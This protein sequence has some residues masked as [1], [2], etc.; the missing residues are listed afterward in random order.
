MAIKKRLSLSLSSLQS[1]P[2]IVAGLMVVPLL[3]LGIGA[4]YSYRTATDALTETTT[5]ITK[6]I[7]PVSNLQLA[8]EKAAMPPNDYIITGDVKERAEFARLSRQTDAAFKVVLRSPFSRDERRSTLAAIKQWRTVKRL[9][10][11]VLATP[12]PRDDPVAV[13]KM[14]RLDAQIGRAVVSLDRIHALA[15]QEIIE[16]MTEVNRQRR[17]A[18]LI[19]VLIFAASVAM[20]TAI[21]TM[22]ARSI[23]R[24]LGILTDGAARFAAGDLSYR[25]PKLALDELD[26]FG[27]TFNAMA[28]R[29][30]TDL[31]ELKAGEAR[32]HAIADTAFDGIITLDAM[33]KIQFVN[34]AI[35]RMHGYAP[36]ELIGQDVTVLLPERFRDLIAGEITRYLTTGASDLLDKTTELST[37]KKDGSEFQVELTAAA[38]NIEGQPFFSGMIRDITQRKEAERLLK[39]SSI[40]DGLTGLYNYAEFHRLLQ[41]EL[42][43]SR[44]YGPPFSLLMLDIDYFKQVNDTNGHQAGDTV[45]VE[46]ADTIREAIRPIDKPARYGGEEFI[47][48]LPETDEAG[49]LITAERIRAHAEKMRVPV[50]GDRSLEITISVGV[51]VFPDD[52]A[53]GED[54]VGHADRAMYAAKAAGRNRVSD[55]A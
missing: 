32:F 26:Q 7:E 54:L 11:A 4:I 34:K 15:H 23:I 44:R 9:S 33:G 39:K 47:I 17:Q 27:R 53:S 6:E 46:L 10:L 3:V 20:A 45:L 51:A 38:W 25:A 5:E 1:R 16:R 42:E 50:G 18:F 52:A 41:E 8:L 29:L 36:D 48:I 19:M 35:E 43:R 55:A 13:E 30:S 22:L 14:Q 31:E 49:A 40:T 37:V 28:D 2:I 24:P 12:Q 21:G